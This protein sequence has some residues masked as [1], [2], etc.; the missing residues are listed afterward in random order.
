MKN[1]L[2]ACVLTALVL[3]LFSCSVQKTPIADDQNA[4]SVTPA[5]S[6]ETPPDDKSVFEI[7]CTKCHE[8]ERA[9]NY[10]GKDTWETV[11]DN[12]IKNHGAVI[13]EGDVPRIVAYLDKTYPK[14]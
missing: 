4:E 1:L 12:M 11:V 13:S 9:T 14:K 10:T 2:S 6:V 8:V 5:K 7:T 3:F